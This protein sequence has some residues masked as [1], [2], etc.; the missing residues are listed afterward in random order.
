MLARE[1][2]T[3]HKAVP[4][5][6]NQ[7]CSRARL[8][9]AVSA[10]SAA[11]ASHVRFGFLLPACMQWDSFHKFRSGKQGSQPPCSIADEMPAEVLVRNLLPDPCLTHYNSSGFN[12]ARSFSL[13]L[14]LAC[15]LACSVSLFLVFF[16]FRR[17]GDAK[18]PWAESLHLRAFVLLSGPPMLEGQV[19]NEFKSPTGTCNPKSVRGHLLA[20][21]RF[22]VFPA[23]V[24]KQQLSVLFPILRPFLSL[25]Q[26]LIT[27]GGDCTVRCIR[28]LLSSSSLVWLVVPVSP[29]L[30]ASK[31]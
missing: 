18:S 13:L 24:R 19:G 1:S 25:G 3:V 7:S 6:A 4:D 10:T 29:T 20:G 8:T 22:L 21:G 26:V 28:L 23:H 15:L 9:S 31:V 30:L 11:H 16:F 17:L 12:S 27:D 5:T 14:L 2:H